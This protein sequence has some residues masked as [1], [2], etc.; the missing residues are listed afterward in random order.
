MRSSIGPVRA[1][2]SGVLSL[3]IVAVGVF[4]AYRIAARQWRTQE[5]F[6]LRAEFESVAGVEE[7]SRVR[8]QGI[9]AGVVE[10]ITLP[11]RPGDPVGVRL[12]V[13]A[14]FRDLIR[15]DAVAR[16]Q[17]QGVVGSKVVEISLG[18]PEAPALAEGGVISTE[19]PVDLEDMLRAA[20]A[21]LAKLDAVA[22]AA[23]QGLGELTEIAG[24]VRSG[25]GTLGRLVQDDEAYQRLIRLTGRG[26]ETLTDLSENLDALKHTWPISR[27]FNNRA[28]FDREKELYRPGA[29]RESRTVAA[30]E[31]FE[32]GR[33]VLTPRGRKTL[34]VIGQ[35]CKQTVS[36]DSEVVIAAFTDRPEDPELAELLTQEQAE[37]VK[38]YLQDQHKVDTI[39]WFRSR[40]VAAIGFGTRLPRTIGAPMLPSPARRI[41][42]IVFTPQT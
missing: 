29:L 20:R 33:A 15:Q 31:L 11:G 27:Y 19:N 39:N 22:T 12:K 32:E 34:D 8:V 18:R 3:A 14:R 38:R 36:K 1:I 2:A 9:D 23:E 21:S 28:F 35:W 17:T 25:E 10:G 26:E 42:L 40:R 5:T 37:A 16:V 24:K 30:A 41:E 6:V 13:D 7:G 4:G